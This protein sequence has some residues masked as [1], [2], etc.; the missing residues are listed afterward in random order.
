MNTNTF[1][2]LLKYPKSTAQLIW[3]KKK[4]KKVWIPATVLGIYLV[5]LLFVGG[6]SA[7]VFTYTLQPK[8]FIQNVSLTGKVIAAKNVDMGFE[9]SARVQKVHVKVGDIVKKGVILASLENGDYVSAVNKNYAIVQSEQAKFADLSS[10]AK[11]EEKKLAE[12]N[13]ANATAVVE[14]SKQ[15]LI[16]QIKDTYT[17]A[18]DAI[19][20]NI[21]GS[22]RGPRSQNPEFL[23]LIDQNTALRTSVG[24]DRYKVGTI[25]DRI[26]NTFILENM[27][28]YREEI[29]QIQ[30]FINDVNTAISIVSEKATAGGDTAY[31]AIISTQ[32][33]NIAQARTEFSLSVSTLN[34]A[35]LAYKNNVN[36][37][38]RAQNELQILNSGATAAQLAQQQAN[39]QSAQAG[40][41][42]ASS[43]LAKTLIRAPFDGV[44]TKVD[45]K[46]GEI[47]SPNTPVISM[48]NDGEYQIETF[49]SENDIA[50][51]SVGQPA[52]ISLDA[53]GRDTFF[54]AVVISVDPA[55][56]LKDGVSTYRTKIQFVGKDEKVKSGMTANIDI[57][58]NRRAD[59]LQIP[60]AGIVLE[61]GIKNIQILEDVTCIS[62]V[63]TTTSILSPGCATALSKNKFALVP[64]I[65]GEISSSGDIEIISGIVAGQTI[66]YSTK[67][68]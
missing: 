8:E 41:G 16:D 64:I 19:R 40:V 45:I 17:K 57:E 26:N 62:D 21:D 24:A 52:K 55:E 38:T 48:L 34:Q 35:E 6:T 13:I 30:K 46:E 68:K 56:T 37:L 7:D 4:E 66:I 28:T 33:N 18:D 10:A 12:D 49:V 29:S 25:L 53:Y 54:E 11:K 20:F 23:H 22:F 36:A 51:L 50:K 27:T 2:T 65:T 44:I 15:T 43:L 42:S 39:I 47:S 1:K 5:S 3:S 63:T 58:T 32:K 31:I 61:S 9:A 67:A 14:I 60:Q 59:I